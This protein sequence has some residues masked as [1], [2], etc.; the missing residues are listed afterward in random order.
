MLGHA[1]ILASVRVVG[2]VD[3]PVTTLQVYPV[4]LTFPALLGGRE[5]ML[6]AIANILDTTVIFVSTE[7]TDSLDVG[8]TVM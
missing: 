3:D 5:V 2:L 6:E 8:C 4:S 1:T 7:N